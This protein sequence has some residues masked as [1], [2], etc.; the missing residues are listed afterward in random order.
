MRFA[1]EVNTRGGA[2]YP[3]NNAMLP[4]ANPFDLQ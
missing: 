2:G 4:R 3:A 1:K